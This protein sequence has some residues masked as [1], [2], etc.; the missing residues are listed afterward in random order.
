MAGKKEAKSLDS[1][2]NLIMVGCVILVIV[3]WIVVLVFDNSRPHLV[4]HDF[5]VERL[6]K[7]YKVAIAGTEDWYY[8]DEIEIGEECYVEYKE[9]KIKAEKVVLT[10]DKAEGFSMI[11]VN[12]GE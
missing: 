4:S 3:A 5:T 6:S 8:V 12:S 11:T 9:G 2:I 7:G 10:P 1:Y